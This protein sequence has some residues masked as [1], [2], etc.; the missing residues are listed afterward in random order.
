MMP[1]L[2]SGLGEKWYGLWLLV[3]TV[4]GFFGLL[5]V[6]LM[7]AVQRYLA[8][9]K[10]EETTYQF[11]QTVNTALL[12]F[13]AAGI[14][15]I[16]LS[17]IVGFMSSYFVTDQELSS[18]FE[19]I[20]FILGINFALSFISA[21]F[22]ALLNTDYHFNITSL[23][24]F[25]SLSIKAALTVIFVYQGFGVI[26]LAVGTI[27]SSIISKLI[28][29]IN[30]LIKI[31]K[32]RFGFQYLNKTKAVQLFKFS[33]NTFIAWVGDILRFSIDNLVI[34]AFLGLSA[35]AIYNIPIRLFK[36]SSQFIT[37]SLSVLQPY[38]SQRVGENNDNDIREKFE[39]ASGV[40][41]A[42]AALFT[43]GLFVFGYDFIN[44]WVD[45][46][47]ELQ[48]MMYVL[49]WLLLLASSQ[50]PSIMVLY[51]HNKHKHYAHQNIAEGVANA[52]ISVIAVQYWGMMGVLLGSLLPTLVTKLVLQ[53][54]LTCH[55][56]QFPRKKYY[57]IMLSSYLYALTISL[58]AINIKPEITSW[59]VLV[60]SILVFLIIFIIGFYFTALNSNA[61]AFLTNKLI[62]V[63][64]RKSITNSI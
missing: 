42:I 40:S 32:L 27:I 55:L 22:K 64:K 24:D 17:I 3:G 53:P 21:P 13:T 20:V 62:A 61:K 28:I 33:L 2:I 41:F 58:I 48:Q 7:S 46:Y 45:N 37:T 4:M 11:N 10:S 14:A 60:C 6:G 25:L 44:L 47:P 30:A 23:A 52:I 18:T 43:S 29:I 31:K 56:I 19:V 63:L 57:K 8:T 5:T 49:P 9:E 12:I 51:A 26:S 54:K 36:Y 50:S 59:L 1:F 34:S 38:F 15:S 16:I 39:L 35:V